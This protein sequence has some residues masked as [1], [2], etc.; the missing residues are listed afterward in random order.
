MQDTG[1]SPDPRLQPI[2]QLTQ[3]TGHCWLGGR[4]TRTRDH[5]TTS[6][7]ITFQLV[8]QPVIKLIEVLE[9]D[10]I[11]FAE[12]LC[13]DTKKPQILNYF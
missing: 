4:Q 1:S 8:K 10:S 3:L 12:A 11:S 2:E 9:V 13:T 5:R 6:K 7:Y